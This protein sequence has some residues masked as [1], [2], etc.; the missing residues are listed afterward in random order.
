MQEPPAIR[1]SV[2]YMHHSG[3]SLILSTRP[4]LYLHGQLRIMLRFPFHSVVSIFRLLFFSVDHSAGVRCFFVFVFAISHFFASL[5]LFQSYIISGFL[6][7]FF[8]VGV[9]CILLLLLWLLLLLLMGSGRRD[10]LIHVMHGDGA[11]ILPILFLLDQSLPR[12]P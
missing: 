4:L 9:V 3:A 1:Y 10:W 8:L 6:V 2:V 7:F 5:L 11:H 12:P